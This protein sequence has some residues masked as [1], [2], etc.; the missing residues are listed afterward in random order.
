VTVEVGVALLE[1]GEGGERGGWE[2]YVGG[3]RNQV[4]LKGREGAEKGEAGGG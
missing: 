3:G 2:I 4:L 1:G